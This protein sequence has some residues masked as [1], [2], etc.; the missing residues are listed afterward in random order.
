MTARRARQPRRRS[1]P[2]PEAGGPGGRPR[3]HR[4]DPAQFVPWPNTVARWPA[5][6]WAARGYLAE[7]LTNDPGTWAPETA[8]EA[9][10][11]ARRERGQAAESRRDVER[12][13]A[14]LER[15]GFRH[16]LRWREPGSS[17][18]ANE[19]HYYGWQVLKCPDA[20]RCAPCTDRRTGTASPQV[21][22]HTESGDPDDQ[23]KH[24][25]AGRSDS[26][27]SDPSEPD[28]SETGESFTNTN[29]LLRGAEDNQT[30]ESG[31]ALASA[32]PDPRGA[33][34]GT[35]PPQTGGVF[36]PDDGRDPE[37]QDQPSLLADLTART[38]ADRDGSCGP[39]GPQPPGP[40][41]VRAD[42]AGDRLDGDRVPRERAH[43][44]AR[45][46]DR[47]REARPKRDGKA[48]TA[49][50]RAAAWSQRSALRPGEQ[51]TCYR[52]GCS[53]AFTARGPGQRYCS[54]ACTR[55][56]HNRRA[57]AGSQACQ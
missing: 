14:E 20:H 25:S 4:G 44:G 50:A 7:M 40:G 8:P 10:N 27:L 9:L 45:K 46:R 30:P 55:A 13:C 21:T 52:P 11:R 1:A 48:T 53:Q 23:G 5:L 41:T 32:P 49:A 12:I 47:E 39:D 29:H 43:A 37:Y 22:G 38:T 3:I 6:S 24:V 36:A 35:P 26:P 15:E 56:E 16:R 2:P 54:P 34:S 51:G 33:S 18:F 57:R 42:P 17:A 31:G 19:V 28:P